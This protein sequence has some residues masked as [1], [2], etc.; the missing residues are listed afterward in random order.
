[1]NNFSNIK[2]RNFF[3]TIVF[4][5]LSRIDPYVFY[6]WKVDFKISPQVTPAQGGHS[7]T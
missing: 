1:M 3:N 5:S 7:V 4:L 6:P 2:A